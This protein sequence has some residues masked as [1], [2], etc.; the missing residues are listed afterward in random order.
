MESTM[1]NHSGSPPEEVM[2]TL[3]AGFTTSYAAVM[4]FIA[5]A[6][7]ES[8]AKAGDRLARPSQA[9]HRSVVAPRRNVA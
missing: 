7:E 9:R 6:K 8:F 3:S 4:T 2:D 5:V 1:R